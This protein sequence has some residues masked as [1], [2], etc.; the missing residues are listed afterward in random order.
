MLVLQ[1]I[2]LREFAH[3]LILQPEQFD[4]NRGEGINKNLKWKWKFF[5][6]NLKRKISNTSIW[7]KKS[8][9]SKVCHKSNV[10][11]WESGMNHV[12]RKLSSS[13]IC[14]FN[15]NS[16]IWQCHVLGHQWTCMQIVLGDK[17][18]NVLWIKSNWAN[19]SY[20]EERNA[21]N[22]NRQLVDNC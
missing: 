6:I 21:R 13:T 5:I 1:I 11:I 20:F 19:R 9:F 18:L 12:Y 16:P 22:E 15:D 10:A 8:P 7:E 2:H 17:Q 4:Q 14:N 3:A